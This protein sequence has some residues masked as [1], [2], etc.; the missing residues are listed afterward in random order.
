MSLIS[1]ISG[2]SPAQ[3][4]ICVYCLLGL[5]KLIMESGLIRSLNYYKSIEVDEGLN[6]QRVRKDIEEEVMAF[7]MEFEDLLA[8][9]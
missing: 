7:E 2:R 4:L 1:I 8:L 3:G 6:H 5:T 9:L